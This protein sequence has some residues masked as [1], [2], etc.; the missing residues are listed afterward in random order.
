MVSKKW[1][2]LWIRD[3]RIKIQA[4]LSTQICLW[5]RQS[6]LTTG[7][8]ASSQVFSANLRDAIKEIKKEMEKADL[9]VMF[10]EMGLDPTN[11]EYHIIDVVEQ[12]S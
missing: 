3:L 11:F 6:D 5:R 4:L 12:K 8:I 2:F 10:V 7:F 9:Q 1:T